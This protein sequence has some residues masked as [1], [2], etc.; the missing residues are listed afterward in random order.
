MST[1]HCFAFAGFSDAEWYCILGLKE[2]D[3]TGLGQV[4]SFRHG[5]RL[6]NVLRKR[7]KDP[8][9]LPAIPDCLNTLPGFAEGQIDWWLGRNNINLVAYE[10]DRVLD[11]LARDAGLYPLIREFQNHRTTL[12]GPEPLRAFAPKLGARFVAIETPNLHLQPGGIEKAVGRILR[13][14]RRGDAVAI[15]AG[16]SAAIIIDMI[17]DREQEHW[18]WDCGSIWDAF[19]GIGGQRQWRADLYA[20]PIKLHLWQHQNLTGERVYSA[21]YHQCT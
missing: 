9:F 17:L 21:I 18:L 5:E 14:V 16:V 20:D 10:R 12:V 3:K 1:G 8:W 19:V 13:E 2:G 11:Y 6:A 4:L 7:Y 15:S